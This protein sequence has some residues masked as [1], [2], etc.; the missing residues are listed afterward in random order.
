MSEAELH[1]N[2][3]VAASQVCSDDLADTG[4]EW[5]IQQVTNPRVVRADPVRPRRDHQV[6]TFIITGL[7]ILA[8]CFFLIILSLI[9]TV[10][11]LRR[12][13][14]KLRVVQQQVEHQQPGGG[15]EGE[16]AVTLLKYKQ[17]RRQLQC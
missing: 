13:I 17:Q 16:L 1:N 11:K 3:S 2:N 12:T 7:A 9:N 6:E 15:D 5:C 8:G 10:S 4:G 14:R